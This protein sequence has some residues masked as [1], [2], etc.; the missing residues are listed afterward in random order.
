MSRFKQYM[1]IIQEVVDIPGVTEEMLHK[2]LFRDV[3]HDSKENSMGGNNYSD[4][5]CRFLIKAFEKAGVI[6]QNG[7]R[8][9]DKEILS[10]KIDTDK[11]Y[12]SALKMLK[13][14][15]TP[16]KLSGV[17]KDFLEK[18]NNDD[19]VTLKQLKKFILQD[20]PKTKIDKTKIIS[21]I[22]FKAYD[23]KELMSIAETMMKAY[24]GEMI[25]G[26]FE[27][28]RNSSSGFLLKKIGEIIPKNQDNMITKIYNMLD[29]NNMNKKEAI[30][31][32]KYGA[33][34]LYEKTKNVNA[35]QQ[36]IFGF[37]DSEKELQLYIKKSKIK[38][39]T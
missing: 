2:K 34:M 13:E 30:E 37:F 26:I 39:P 8:I 4:V 35:Q 23:P 18:L 24:P 19:G 29:E 15:Q 20:L 6:N 14:A 5:F 28:A 1:Q 3:E 10:A 11:I 36:I 16:E 9:V 22:N 38:W 33:A 21:D 27:K 25:I 17:K 7:Y 12:D 31:N 32:L